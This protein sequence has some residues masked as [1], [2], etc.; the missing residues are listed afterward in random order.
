L[1]T[2]HFGMSAQLEYIEQQIGEDISFFCQRRDFNRQAAFLFT[3]V[4][5]TLSA[6][7]TVAIGTAEKLH[8]Q[9]LPILAMVATAIAS[10]FGAWQALFAN[11]KLWQA[12]NA[13]LATLY[14]LRWDIEYR[15]R[16]TT[17]ELTKTEIDDYFQ[18][19]KTIRNAAEEA[20]KRAYST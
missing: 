19:L 10:I 14:D 4:P 3:I 5:A 20:L 15:K 1:V 18:R 9:W 8:L 16:D 12:N 11:R 13:T 2:S 6:F 7:A 17:S